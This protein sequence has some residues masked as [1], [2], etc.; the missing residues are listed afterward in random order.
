MVNKRPEVIYK[1]SNQSLQV[2]GTC[3]NRGSSK[4]GHDLLVLIH[5]IFCCCTSAHLLMFN[6]SIKLLSGM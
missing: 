1:Q 5:Y 6:L 3:L 2:Q 4:Q